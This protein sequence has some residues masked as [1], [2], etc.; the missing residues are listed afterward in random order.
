[1]LSSGYLGLGLRA[2][3]EVANGADR[4]IAGLTRIVIPRDLAPAGALDD[5]SM[6]RRQPRD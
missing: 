4:V 2:P 5:D 1:M 3:Y 6:C